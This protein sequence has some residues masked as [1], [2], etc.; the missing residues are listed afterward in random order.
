MNA[1]LYHNRSEW[2]LRCNGG[3]SEIVNLRENMLR[4]LI[5]PHNL[6]LIWIGFIVG[7][8]VHL[9]DAMMHSLGV[10]LA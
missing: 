4:V 8:N 10:L 2:L 5:L 1:R 3:K 7:S 9:I 6:T